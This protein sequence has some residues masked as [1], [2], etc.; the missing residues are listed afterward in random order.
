MKEIRKRREYL[1]DLPPE[2]VKELVA[3]G[4]N[5]LPIDEFLKKWDQYRRETKPQ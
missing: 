3:Q 2:F 1:P 4:I 5:T